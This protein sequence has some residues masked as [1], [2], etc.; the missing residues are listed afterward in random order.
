MDDTPSPQRPIR[1]YVLR[2][3]RMGTGQQRALAELGPRYVLPYA[4]QPLDFAAVFGRTAPVVLEIGFGMGD[5]TAQVAA[6]SPERDLLGVEVHEPGVGAL[7]RHIGERG[8]ENVRILRHDAVEVLREMIPPASLAGV[9]VWFPD[10]WHKK[11]HHKRRLIQ[12]AFVELLASRLAPGGYLHC[13]TDWQPYAEQMLE[14]LS[15]SSL[16][17]TAAGY[18]ERPAW[19]PLTKFEARGLRL[20]HGVWDLVFT[21]TS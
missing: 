1:S 13:A 14:V 11:R 12:P 8:L 3:G 19:R 18:A 5:A 17:N 9:H 6:A 10:P 4:A 15:A 7:L 21:R 20:G 2:A 16:A